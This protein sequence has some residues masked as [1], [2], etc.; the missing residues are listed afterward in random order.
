MTR[1]LPQ[2]ARALAVALAF[3]IVALSAGWLSGVFTARAQ[4]ATGFVA[5]QTVVVNTDA[6]N[7]RDSA[8]TDA[9]VI[10]ILPNGTYGVVLSG[11][12]SDGTYDWY[13][14]E[15]DGV[16]GYVAGDFLADA[17]TG[18][19]AAGATV[20]VNTDLLNLREL[21]ST[22]GAVVSELAS[23]A[24]ATVLDGPVEADGY[25]WYQVETS[26]GTGWVVRDYLAY[27]AAG[28]TVTDSDATLLAST[29]DSA[30]TLLVN[31]DALNVRDIA[32]LSGTVLETVVS[33]D[34]VSTTGLTETVDGY[35]WAEV[36]TASG[37]T[38]WVVASY[39]TSDAGAILS[40]GTVAVV[41][42]DVLNLRDSASINGSILAEL[43]TGEEVTILSASEAADGYLWFQVETTAA[44]GWVVGDYLSA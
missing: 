32:G 3:A 9:A 31:T 22:S 4:D 5:D 20:F 35:E 14:I 41:D 8:G 13:L 21:A 40:I 11:P 7:L 24:T 6:L 15:V 18:A 34:S 26:A 29:T 23:G 27:S 33:G 16:S 43:G 36:Q 2:P 39:L 37:T 17:S 19:I 30:S 38:G 42:T 25:T 12:E 1:M 28:T 44:T 10:E